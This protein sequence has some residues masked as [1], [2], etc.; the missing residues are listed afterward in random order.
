MK[1]PI[2]PLAELPPQ[3]N[4]VRK[5]ENRHQNDRILFNCHTK[6]VIDT[7]TTIYVFISLKC[8]PS[9]YLIHTDFQTPQDMKQLI[10]PLAEL[11]SQS[12][13]VPTLK[14]RYQNDRILFN[15]HTKYVI[16]TIPTIYVFISPKC[17]PS[18]YL[19][20]TEFQTPQDMKQLISLLAKLPSQSNDV[21]TLKSGHQNDRI[22][23]NCHTKYEIDTIP[24]IYVC[25]SSKYRPSQSL[26]SYRVPDSSRH[27]A[28]N[29]ST[30][31]ITFAE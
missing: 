28:T 17:R 18:N 3:S 30:C 2:F 12:N 16:D 19:I 8:R 15:C 11:P 27:E 5:L 7:I 13:D 6:Y 9:N 10:S 26:S 14:S 29:F 20:H 31:R 23:F 1:Q 25:I 21:C 24:T 4:D 22:L